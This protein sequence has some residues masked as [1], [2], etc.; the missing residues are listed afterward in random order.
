[1][2]LKRLSSLLI[3]TSLFL[4]GCGDSPAPDPEH[5]HQWGDPTYVWSADYSVCTAERV[6]KLDASHIEKEE[7][8][9]KYTVVTEPTETT[10]G[11]ARYVASFN[12]PAFSS[13]TKDITIP[14]I[15][16][17]DSYE[18][19]VNSVKSKHNYTL[20]LVNQWDI[21][22]TPWVEFSLY[23]INDDAIFDDYSPY[24]YSGYI[25][26][27]G[28]GIVTFQSVKS[29][30][31]MMMG[32]F[33]ATNLERSVSEVYPLAL[34][35]ILKEDFVYSEERGAYVCSSMAAMAVIGNLAFSDYVELVSAPSYFTMKYVNNSLVITCIFDVRYFDEE[36]KHTN[37][38]VTLTVSNFEKTH[39]SAIETYVKTPDY[40]Y[41]APAEWD[42]DSKEYFDEKYNGYYPPFIEGLSYSWKMGLIANE[43]YYRPIV[44][45]YFAGNLIP[46]YINKLVEEGFSE[47]TNPGYIEYQKTVV[48]ELLVHTYSVKMR[49]TDPNATDKSGMKYSYLYPNGVSTFIFVHNFKTKA[50]ITDV[51]K[52]NDYISK[53][54][55]KDYFPLF[56]LADDTK[57][58]IFKDA[59][60]TDETMALFLKGDGND[61]FRIFP[62]TKEHALTCVDDFVSHF[63]LLGFEGSSS[64]MFQQYWLTDE[65]GSKIKISDPF[66]VSTWTSSSRLDVRIEI[67]KDTLEH[68]A[69]E[70][71]YL[72][73]ISISNQTTSFSLNDTFT[74]DGVVTAH[75]SDGYE[76]VVTPTSISTP[77]MSKAGQQLVIVSYT[78]KN[79]ETV[80]TNYTI[81]VNSPETK[82]NITI[83]PVT[84]AEI[85]ISYPP[86]G[87]S[88]AGNSVNISVDSVTEGY[89]V[90]GITVMCG[91]KEVEASGPIP[92]KNGFTFV[93]PSGDV[94]V[95]ANV[96]VVVPSHNI[97]Y[98]VY[99][100][101]DNT[102]FNPLNYD[103]V[104]GSGS[105]LPKT[106]DENST[107]NFSVAL[108]TGYT[109]NFATIGTNTFTN[110]FF[111]YQMGDSDLEVII[112][113]KVD[114]SG[115]GGDTTEFGGT[116]SWYKGKLGGKDTYFRLTFNDDGTG[117]YV[118]DPY[119]N[120]TATIYFTYV[121]NGDKIKL[122]LTDVGDGF[123][124]FGTYR[125]FAKETLGTTNT[126][127]EVNPDGSI[128]IDL[129]NNDG[130]SGATSSGNYT[131]R[132]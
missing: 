17:V 94:T 104:I 124:C 110:S 106:A 26:Q 56:N 50:T 38:T 96:E 91:D 123:N 76:E 125:P 81:T 78:D 21:E 131:F 51:G 82:Y 66:Y 45:D 52:L 126:T 27:K 132:K 44:E 18:S 130:G 23:N 43:G 117:T 72:E 101:V 74:F 84:G 11:L 12:N 75:Y 53:T 70:P 10:E 105:N 33:V 34:E 3:A 116:Y 39:N 36:E 29:S 111:Q 24:N 73:S 9:S 113:V 2:K 13:Q 80:S 92:P 6:C 122:T 77:D 35:H 86:S 83:I 119:N 31:S 4:V 15:S 90:T 30:G 63:K 40:T 93:M 68:W 108:K 49:F 46:N 41:V 121:L 25:K 129:Y 22:E 109:F 65:Y 37:A 98:S 128:S 60:D 55:V 47:V 115:G 19:A 67:T 69:E 120:G 102:T 14:T 59:T 118:R 32:Y 64:T 8:T 57:V 5:H 87:Q 103:D 127:A 16:V 100:V 97:S 58:T 89:T 107:I 112:Y 99:E 71:V 42:Y 62:D 114:Q 48:D 95:K 28:Q 1:M 61:F 54:S 7:S 88:V 79:G 20:H 85:S